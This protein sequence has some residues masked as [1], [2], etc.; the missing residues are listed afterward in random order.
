MDPENEAERILADEWSRASSDEFLDRCAEVADQIRVDWGRIALSDRLRANVGQVA[1][2]AV[3]GAGTVTGLI[4]AAETD[5][6]R[7]AAAGGRCYIAVG[8]IGI[9]TGL[10]EAGSAPQDS[11]AV[12]RGWTQVLRQLA[13]AGRPVSIALA[14]GSRHGGMITRSGSD[15]VDVARMSDSQA[16]FDRPVTIATRAIA[17]VWVH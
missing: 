6:I 17:A 3:D 12:A 11:I 14:D 5:W 16:G 15:H 13:V 2:L 9:V 10:A 8:K 7:V 1:T 4:E